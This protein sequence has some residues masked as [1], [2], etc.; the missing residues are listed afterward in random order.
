MLSWW[1]LALFAGV[2][3]RV[4]QLV[5]RSR[6]LVCLYKVGPALLPKGGEHVYLSSRRSIDP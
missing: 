1:Y 2:V 6:F 5:R 3:L 4:S